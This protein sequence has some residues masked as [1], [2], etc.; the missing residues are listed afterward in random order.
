MPQSPIQ[1]LGFA[2][3]KALV[4]KPLRAGAQQSLFVSQRHGLL[5][6]PSYAGNIGVVANPSAVTT[7][8]ALATTYV[9]L[10]LS[11]PA[12][13]T[14]NLAVLNVSASLL[15]APSTITT[16]FLAG[17]YAAGG[18]TAHTTALTPL[19]SVLGVTSTLQGL[20]DSACT[21]VGTPAYLRVLGQ[22]PTATTSFAV[23]VNIDGS[24]I[25][26]PGGYVC[27]ATNIAGPA[28]GF[29]GS[30]MWEEN[31]L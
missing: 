6:E 28:S 2:L 31:P 8:A 26:P 20:A 19:A 22:A 5:Y 1:T 25:I 21:L 13:S 23:N 3:N 16:M 12:T 24:I 10:C 17:G 18:V 27:I 15:V 14:V 30:M 4:S 7:S 29:V 11:N 9:G